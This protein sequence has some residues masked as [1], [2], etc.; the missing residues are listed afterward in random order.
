MDI[1]MRHR[2]VLNLL[3]LSVLPDCL[4]AQST[5]ARYIRSGI[6][7]T[8]NQEAVL[9]LAPQMAG[10]S[11]EITVQE[12][13]TALNVSNVEVGVHFDTRRSR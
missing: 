9:D 7:L 10:V 2:L 5:F 8:L 3:A 1:R 4:L 12:N 6:I 13:A 11:Q